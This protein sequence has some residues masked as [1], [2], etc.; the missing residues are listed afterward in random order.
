MIMALRLSLARISGMRVL[1]EEGRLYDEHGRNVSD[2]WLNGSF[3]PSI[4]ELMRD[5]HAYII[6]RN[7]L[8]YQH[9]TGK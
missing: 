5:A 7:G 8:K 1:A 6:R 3:I 9:R 2:R 4:D